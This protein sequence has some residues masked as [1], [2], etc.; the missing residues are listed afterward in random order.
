MNTFVISQ[1]D[2]AAIAAIEAAGKTPW[3]IVNQDQFVGAYMG[4][5]AARE[6]KKAGDLA[7]TIMKAS[8]LE[9]KIAEPVVE[10]TQ[11]GANQGSAAGKKLLPNAN[12]ILKQ[13]GCPYCGDL[14]NGV[15]YDDEPGKETEYVFCQV[16]GTSFSSID[17]HL[18]SDKKAKIITHKS[19]IV[20][21]CKTVWVIA[22]DM[23]KANPNTKRSA[24]LEACVKAGIAYYTA[25]TQYQQFLTVRKEELARK[26]GNV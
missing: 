23:L 1:N 12:E 16:C 10:K 6:A 8:E 26:N 17:G 15:T 3:V 14:H 22:D 20:H 25:R 4:R 9:F 2:Q 13:H 24:I 11:T 21:P 5:D 7:G 19:E 18:R